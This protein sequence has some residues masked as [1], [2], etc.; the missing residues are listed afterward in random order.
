MFSSVMNEVKGVKE[1]IRNAT[2]QKG[3]KKI[4]MDIEITYKELEEVTQE[5]NNIMEKIQEKSKF[6]IDFEININVL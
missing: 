2:G 6:D 5:L 1:E 4:R 3:M